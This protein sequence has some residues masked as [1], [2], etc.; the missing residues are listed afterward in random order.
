VLFIEETLKKESKLA[1]MLNENIKLIINA[2]CRMLA[3]SYLLINKI[4]RMCALIFCALVKI[5]DFLYCAKF[6]KTNSFCVN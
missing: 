2:L 1:R 5:A 4:Q 3:D 6:K